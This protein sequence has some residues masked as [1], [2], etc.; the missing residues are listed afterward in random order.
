[1]VGCVI[2]FFDIASW[3]CAFLKF[4][5]LSSRGIR[6]NNKIKKR[7][8]IQP[9]GFV[10]GNTTLYLTNSDGKII[11]A[12]LS[13]GK[14]LNIENAKVILVTSAFHM[15]RA[16]RIFEAADIKVIPFAVDFQ[17][18]KKIIQL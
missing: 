11:I 17:N 2:C 14:V 5:L 7:K 1:M 4:L 18:S 16:Q 3:L 12:D 8:D 9:V 13:E 6:S 15:R 10:I